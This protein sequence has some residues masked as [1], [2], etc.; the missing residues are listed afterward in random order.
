MLDI[1]LRDICTLLY[2]SFLFGA[3]FLIGKAVWN[4]VRDIALK[5]AVAPALGGI[6][7]FFGW[8]IFSKIERHY[9]VM[10]DGGDLGP[11]YAYIVFFAC[12]VIVPAFLLSGD[13]DR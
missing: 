1:F 5:K 10:A 3:I 13:R 11:I 12:I 9:E 4:I 8:W 2:V 7:S 6:G